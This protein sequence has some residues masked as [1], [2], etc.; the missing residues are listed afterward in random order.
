MVANVRL[1]QDRYGRSVRNLVAT[2]RWLQQTGVPQGREPTLG[3]G[4]IKLEMPRH[5]AFSLR[6]LSWHRDK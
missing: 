5:L 4:A 2:S 6:Q 1:T 3:T